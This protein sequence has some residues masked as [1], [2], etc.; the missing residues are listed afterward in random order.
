MTATTSRARASWARRGLG[1]RAPHPDAKAMLL[2]QLYL[3]LYDDGEFREA[4]EIAVQATEL[5]VLPDVM[6][7]DAARAMQ[8]LGDIEGAVRHLR[9]AV[10]LGPASRRAF[11]WWTLGS[12]L[13][14]A[15][16]N[17]EA[18][19]ALERAAR[20]GT[21]DKPLYQG[22]LALAKCRAGRK[23]RDLD[24]IIERLAGCPAG[25]GYG[26]FVLGQLAYQSSRF[27]DARAYLQAFVG[28]T[29][30]ARR[31]MQIAL[32]GEVEMAQRTL[33]E[34]DRAG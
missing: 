4:Y 32:S 14:L 19:A 3:A 8:A 33:D 6:H 23:V 29:A 13:F 12:V 26:R 31:P 34:I 17:A 11:H 9:L 21:N 16:R 30:K 10:R 18:I 20:W 27:E 25:Q 15:G 1:T 7:E 22:H 5:D 24:A 2:H 28:R